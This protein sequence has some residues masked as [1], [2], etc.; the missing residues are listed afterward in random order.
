[1]RTLPS[2]FAAL[3]ALTRAGI[4]AP[5]AQLPALLELE[6][7]SW[8]DDVVTWHGNPRCTD[9][10][11]K[12]TVKAAVATVTELATLNS[13][14]YR[15]DGY[16]CACTLTGDD[17]LESWVTAR[18]TLAF[19][20]LLQEVLARFNDADDEPDDAALGLVRI[21]LYDLERTPPA[22]TGD[23]SIDTLVE[24]ALA[25]LRAALPGWQER[26]AGP[27]GDPVRELAARR[28][29]DR[30][31]NAR[32]HRRV[33]HDISVEDLLAEEDQLVSLFPPAVEVTSV[34]EPWGWGSS[35]LYQVLGHAR[36]IGDLPTDG[37]ADRLV[38]RVSALAAEVL[39]LE[40]GSQV[41]VLGPAAADPE[42]DTVEI[43]E[44]ALQLAAQ[45][46]LDTCDGVIAA[47]G[48][49]TPA[50]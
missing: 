23:P 2:G 44:L 41:H 35:L 48:V 13:G 39:N 6:P 11:S 45:E 4:T 18:G 26:I 19:V 25:H 10:G 34:E 49:L 47:R 1:M 46:D 30:V 43:V 20:L 9:F 33:G 24:H 8:G 5:V 15:S 12:S 31:Q 21:A 36:F 42:L 37:P 16:G 17:A 7:R 38:V 50:G 27:E 40:L 3:A 29:R 14:D 28:A 32:S 22:R